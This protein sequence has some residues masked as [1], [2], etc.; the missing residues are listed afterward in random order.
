MFMK[1]LILNL[2]RVVLSSAV[3]LLICL[4]P[5]GSYADIRLP[6]LFSAGMVLQQKDHVAFWGWATA[7]EEITIGASWRD[8]KSVVKGKSG[9]VRVGPGGGRIKK[10]NRKTDRNR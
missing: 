4:I 3:G 7:Y 5:I 8:R 9:Y 10:K 6:A 1:L 2:Q